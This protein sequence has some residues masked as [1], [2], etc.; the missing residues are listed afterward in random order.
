MK[1]QNYLHLRRGSTDLL[2]N[3]IQEICALSP[4]QTGNVCRQQNT[5]KQCLVTKHVDFVLTGQS[6]SDI[7]K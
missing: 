3:N 1:K 6:I 7:F 4:V 5:I 2:D